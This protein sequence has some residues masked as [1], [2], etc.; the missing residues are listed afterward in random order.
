[1]SN[2]DQI[3]DYC[4]G[5]NPI[6]TTHRGGEATFVPGVMIPEFSALV[7]ATT[8]LTLPM[9]VVLVADAH[10]SRRLRLEGL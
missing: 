9:E 3:A 10:L 1:M 4:L 2:T 7:E 6:I 8:T 5:R